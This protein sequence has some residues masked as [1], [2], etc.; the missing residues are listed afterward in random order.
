M[1]RLGSS[2]SID[3][4]ATRFAIDVS[5]KVARQ[6]AWAVGVEKRAARV[7]HVESAK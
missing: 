1:A 3:L 4:V 6:R 5:A 7:W 2:R